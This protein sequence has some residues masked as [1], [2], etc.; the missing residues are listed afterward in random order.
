VV[1]IF[2][3]GRAIPLAIKYFVA[4]YK[5]KNEKGGIHHSNYFVSS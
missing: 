2:D 4:V 3:V 5:D 1:P